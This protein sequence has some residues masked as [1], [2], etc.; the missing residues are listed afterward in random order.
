MATLDTTIIRTAFGKAVSYCKRRPVGR[1]KEGILH[2]L[3]RKAVNG[4]RSWRVI[5]DPDFHTACWAVKHHRGA[6]QHTITLGIKAANMLAEAKRDCGRTLKAF[7]ISLI[8]HESAHGLHTDHDLAKLSRLCRDA[9]VPF[10]LLNLFEDARIEHTERARV[11]DGNRQPRFG[12]SKFIGVPEET[13]KPTVFFYTHNNC[14]ASSYSYPAGQANRTTRWTGSRADR[15]YI[16]RM[17]GRVCAADTTEDLI[18]LCKEWI[19]RFPEFPEDFPTRSDEI[20][21][22]SCP[23]AASTIGKPGYSPGNLNDGDGSERVN[24]DN[25]V[26]SDY[27]NGDTTTSE[28]DREL[29]PYRVRPHTRRYLASHRKVDWAAVRRLTRRLIAIIHH[30]GSVPARMSE[31][32]SRI[33]GAAAICRRAQAFRSHR[34][35]DGP[36]KLVMV[37]DCST[38]MLGGD[39]LHGFHFMLALINLHRRGYIKA[40]LFLTGDGRHAE[41]KP[42]WGWDALKDILALC[43]CES[44]R[45]TLEAPRVA[46]A[47]KDSDLTI[48]YTDGCLTDGSVDANHYRKHGVDMLGAV[49]VTSRDLDDIRAEM[50]RHFGAYY[51]ERTDTQLASRIINHL[52]RKAVK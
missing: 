40:R 12:W 38:S 49:T 37:L 36:R 35:G 45:A 46:A 44:V 51:A 43:G 9:D 47:V 7:G 10:R 17:Y 5:Y 6:L 41:V 8:W 28:E 13:D 48:V 21:G 26:P 39:F 31:S 27:A 3:I 50:S 11:K 42:S 4:V 16:H 29:K 30:A 22:D 20:G 18:P 33:D 23:V 15:G 19:E 14:E 25:E 32:G 34:S 24:T 1:Q 2:Y 52:A